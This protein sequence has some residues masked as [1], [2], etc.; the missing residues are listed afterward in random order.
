MTAAPSTDRLGAV[1]VTGAAAGLGLAI[2]RL[3]AEE[4][5]SVV[6]VD[7]DA[8]G[9]ERAQSEIGL[10]A[11]VGDVADWA[12]HERAAD[13]AEAAG[14]L[15][16]WVNN[17]GIDL[18]GAAHEVTPEEVE[19]GLRVLL[20]SAIAGSAVAVRR[21][22]RSG[23][24]AIVN[25]SSIQGVVAFPRYLVYGV[26]KAG[27]LQIARSIAVD[28]G[29]YGIRCATVL[30]GTMDTPLTRSTLPADLPL[31]EALA[32]EGELAPLGRVARAEEVAE[33]VCFLLS[34]RSSYVNGAALVVD[35]GASARC[36]A[37]PPLDLAVPPT[38]RGTP[39][40]PEAPSRS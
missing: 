15:A 26:A 8:A 34:E 40:P 5:T 2:A 13:A 38:G 31:E 12:T 19:H 7:V 22:L 10:E 14:R 25:V 27:M 3:L 36:Y 30:P 1:V 4:G 24:G 16:G 35:G 11:I 23:G 21:M 37:Y 39:R 6:G 33:V 32:R 18:Q 29:R 28:Y 17:A 20:G 9:L